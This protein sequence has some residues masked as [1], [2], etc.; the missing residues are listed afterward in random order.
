MLDVFY[1]LSSAITRVVGTPWALLLAF[2]VIA[3]W[4]VTGPMFDFSDTWQLAINTGTTIVTFLMVFVI[5]STQ[6]REAKVTQLKL[7]EL[8]RAVEGARNELIA[9]EEAS[10]ERVQAHAEQFRDFAASVDTEERLDELEEVAE[11]AAASARSTRSVSR[12][13]ATTSAAS[14]TTRTGGGAAGAKRTNGTARG[15]NG[16]RRSRST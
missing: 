10:E 11:K 15:V 4:A 3:A 12:R 7:D 13:K 16:T 6:N 5:Q 9:L 8:I 14:G 2:L 1:R